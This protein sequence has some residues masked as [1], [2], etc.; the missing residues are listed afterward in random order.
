M[1]FVDELGKRNLLYTIADYEFKIVKPKNID[2]GLTILFNHMDKGDKI[3]IDVDSD[4][5]G[6]FSGLIL[7]KLLDVFKYDNYEV[8][9]VTRKRHQIDYSTISHI[10]KDKFDLVFICDSS[11][12]FIDGLK[13]LGGKGIDTIILDHH[14]MNY[15]EELYPSNINVINPRQEGQVDYSEISAG[16]LCF[17]FSYWALYEREL[18]TELNYAELFILGYITIY[19]DCCDLS[20]KYNIS[21]LQKVY[22][23]KK[24]IPIEVSRFMNDYDDLNRN[25][26]LYKLAPKIN[27]Q[28]RLNRISVIY[29]NLFNRKDNMEVIEENYKLAKDI[30]NI[31]YCNVNKQTYFDF[32]FVNLDELPSDIYFKYKSILRNFTGLVANQVMSADNRPCLVVVSENDVLLGGSIREPFNRNLLRV[33]QLVVKA[34]GHPSAFGLSFKKSECNRVVKFLIKYMRTNMDK[35]TIN[36]IIIDGDNMNLGDIAYMSKGMSEY[37]EISGMNL[38]IAYIDK[39]IGYDMEVKVFDKYTRIQWGNLK[40]VSFTTVNYGSR[41]LIKPTLSKEGTKYFVELSI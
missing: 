37:N 16:F 8:G 10:I 5:D 2:K 19:T 31:I 6:F 24:Y 32:T 40:L 39:T 41:I 36:N 4:V 38:P 30:I 28:I 18:C 21:I 15:E 25:F 27:S 22:K 17:L 1:Y 20:N 35:K 14:E 9:R 23:F 26:I 34:G 33:A 12:N 29:D 11:V 3:F 7:K 13:I